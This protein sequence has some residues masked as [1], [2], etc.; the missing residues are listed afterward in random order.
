MR[1]VFCGFLVL[2]VL[3]WL[4]AALPS[5]AMARNHKHR[6]ARPHLA[7]A[8]HNDDDEDGEPACGEEP[9]DADQLAA[10]RAMAAEQCDCDSA[11]N[12]DG[13]VS[14]VDEVADAAVEAG[15]LRDA[16]E[17]VAEHCAEQS[18]CGRP[19]FVTCC[20]TDED[21]H[22]KCRI[23]REDKCTAPAG[24]T[25]CVGAASSCCDACGA[26]GTCPPP[27][28]TTT[29]TAPPPETTTTVPTETTTTTTGPPPTTIQCCV[30]SSAT[31]AFDTCML[32][33]PE[34]CTAQGGQDAGPG[35]C[36]PNPCPPGGATTTTTAPPAT[37]TTT[38]VTT[39]T[40]TTGPVA[41]TTT[42]VTTTTTTTTT[43]PIATTT[44]IVTTTT[45]PITTTTTLAGCCGFSPKPSELSF[46]TGVG[47]GNCGTVQLSNG[48]VS[49]NLACSGLFTGGGGNTVP[50]PYAVPDMG[51][52]LTGVSA[53]SGTALTLANV[54]SNDAGAT[55]RNCTS[56]GC[57]FG[58]P[59]PIPNAGSPATSVCVINSVTTDATGTA[60][61]STGASSLSLPLN[62]EIFLTGDI[63]PDVAG[64]QPCPV[65]LSNVCHGGPNNGMACTPADSPQNATFPTTHDCP[66]PVALDIGGLPIAFDLTTGTKSV[67]AVNN[68]ASG[69]NNVFCGFCRDI[70]NLGTGC[71]AGDP[72]PACPTPNPSAPVACTSN[73]GCPAEY[74]DCVQRSAGAFGPAGGGAH[75]INETGT[76]AGNMTDG[77][78]HASTLVSIFCIQPTFNP[79]VDAAGDLP[80]PGAVSLFGTAQLLP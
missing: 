59:L 27:G 9:D 54:K 18:T 55:N 16:C 14:C 40:T 45:T 15:L 36:S 30:Q 20:R 75:T 34:Q 28:G 57:L 35:S 51:S 25:A 60:D 65:C 8:A 3:L 1:K 4:I 58:P 31:G 79:T 11:S 67:T 22:T 72:N 74:P 41:T 77:A 66:P 33:T 29:T 42:I 17:E 80:G 26:G 76:P 47:S 39:T 24:G 62:S 10:V 43:G 2:S 19:G 56:V 13:Y 37:T 7:L 48:T 68:T 38:E 63:A 52:S 61:C 49:K 6:G 64:L 21:G 12:H 53:C 69:Q 46:T 73:A 44:T 70:N 5:T 78:G 23:K 50:L 32:L 71:F